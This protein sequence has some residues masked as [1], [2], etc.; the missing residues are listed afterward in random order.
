MFQLYRCLFDS[1]D[2]EA[3]AALETCAGALESPFVGDAE[4]SSTATTMRHAA[5]LSHTLGLGLGLK[6]WSMRHGN[7]C[8]KGPVYTHVHAHVYTACL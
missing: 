8:L 5:F 6:V 4:Q 3:P 1:T 2:T 7:G